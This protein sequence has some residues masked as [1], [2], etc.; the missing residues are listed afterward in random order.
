MLMCLLG[1]HMYNPRQGKQ[2]LIDVQ[3]FLESGVTVM[4]SG[5][6]LLWTS[7]VVGYLFATGK[8]H[9][10]KKAS[11]LCIRVPLFLVVGNV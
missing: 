11:G 5:V 4:L 7:E 9:K 6:I 1:Q 10:V 3:T 2:T 8:V